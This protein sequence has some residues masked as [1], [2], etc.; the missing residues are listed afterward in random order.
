MRREHVQ[1]IQWDLTR[2]NP[3]IIE[4]KFSNLYLFLAH[5][6]LN[7]MV[8]PHLALQMKVHLHLPKMQVKNAFVNRLNAKT[9]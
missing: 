3:F 6:L 1:Y 4:Q 7:D 9:Y 8:R 5:S 2:V